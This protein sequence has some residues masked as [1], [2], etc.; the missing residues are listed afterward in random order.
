MAANW[1]NNPALNQQQLSSSFA[2]VKGANEEDSSGQSFMCFGDSLEVQ[3]NKPPSA[4]AK[5]LQGKNTAE[6]NTEAKQGGRVDEL[7]HKA[8]T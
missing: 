6:Q 1:Y 8:L 4:S 2:P 3:A 7:S 5:Y